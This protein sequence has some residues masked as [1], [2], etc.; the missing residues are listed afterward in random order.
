MERGESRPA[1]AWK[2][3]D[4]RILLAVNPI[5][6][7]NQLPGTPSSVWSVAGAGD[8]T[9]QGFATNISVDHGQTVSFKIN[10]SA[11]APYHIDIYR[12]GYYQG[13][14]A[15]LVTTISSSQTLDQVQPAPL[16]NTTT[17]LIDAGNW[18][19]SASWVVPASATSGIYFAR[20]ARDDT[21]GASQIFFIVRDDE[22]SSDILFQTS[23]TTWQAY[24]TWGGIS[25]YQ[26]TS[27]TSGG[28]FKVS[29]NRPLIIDQSS[30]GY[31]D[32]N[33]PWHAE[34]PMVRWL[35]ANGYNVSYFTDVDS[36]R[37]GS[38]ILNHKIFM[39]V[40]H[41]EYWSG[42]QRANVVAARDAGVNLAFFSGNEGYWKT[43]W[44]NS[45][46]GSG[47]PYR[48]LVTYKESK[49][50]A[51][52]PLDSAP[53]WTWT[54]T[55]RDPNGSLP[56]DGSLPENAMTGTIYMDDRT[57]TDLGISMTVPAAAAN[58]R[59][60]RNTSVANL[61]SGQV[62]TLGQFVVGYEVDE[63]LDNG[64]R[65]AGLIDMSSTTFSTTEPCA[66]PIGNTG[67]SGHLD[68]QH[69]A[70][71]RSSGALVFGAGTVQ[72]SWGLDGNHNDTTTTPD[73][74]M[75]QATVNLLADMN[76]QPATLQSGLVW[77]TA[78]TDVTLPTSTITSP[79]AGASFT[80][81]TSVTITGTATDAGGG[82]VAGVEVSTDGGQTWHPA[83]GRASWSYTWTPAVTGP[84]VIRS[85]ATDDSGN[86]ETPSAGVSG[87]V[88]LAP[89]ST[90]GLVAAYNFD[91]GS[92][93]TVT[94]LS[95][96]GNTGTISNATWTSQ[97]H[98]GSALSFNG[99]NSWVTIN[100]STSLH[101]SSGMTLEAWVD[102]ATV[103]NSSPVI[104][105][106]GSGNCAV[107]PVQLRYDRPRHL[108]QCGC[109]GTVHCVGQQ[110]PDAEYLELPRRH[111]RRIDPDALR[112]RRGGE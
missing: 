43:R 101:L 49:N 62:A 41:D 112:Q 58:L 95:G 7:E 51:I 45:I 86:I 13:N 23:D 16:T 64:F 103:T 6:A 89:T 40:G 102:P 84:V 37:N 69:H 53:T 35:E 10:D 61:A 38:L 77:A 34:Y 80:A 90:T 91:A 24:N 63:D 22:G 11:R 97:G 109:P 96:N 79:S 44:E 12:M 30:D 46:D 32:Y 27:N 93:T 3:L 5:V 8:S 105:K 85:R 9:I 54:G 66:G 99:T 111:L 39:S 31:N 19:V 81:G 56:R 100:D 78:S 83:T 29:Y 74:A 88:S 57:T 21:G 71:S 82:V 36:D 17:G 25:L 47:T 92:G 18:A 107:L 70:L 60:W 108:H 87:T 59:F 55:W 67:R 73:L 65:P 28:G 26:G 15:R 98:S 48:T 20:V 2:F 14:G 33:S 76:V 1:L 106:Q 110:G 68:S 75:Q 42:Q 94:D 4:D 104:F 50:G 52:D 72:W